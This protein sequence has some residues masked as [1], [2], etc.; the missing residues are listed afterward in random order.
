MP[1]PP[2]RNM[3]KKSSKIVNSRLIPKNLKELETKS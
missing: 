3:I 1:S 2:L